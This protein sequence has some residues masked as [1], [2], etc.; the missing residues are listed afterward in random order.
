M[1]IYIHF[2]LFVLIILFGLYLFYLYK[3]FTKPETKAVMINDEGHVIDT[4]TVKL[5]QN[6]FKWRKKSYNTIKPKIKLFY[7]TYLFYKVKYADPI[8][9]EDM[10]SSRLPSDVYDSILDAEIVKKL[11][12]YSNGLG[13]ELNMKTILIGAGI[14]LAVIFMFMM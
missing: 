11:N 6:I 12:N 8:K 4:F 5:D 14:L 13:L 2:T 1:I 10:N 3:N 7:K 9:L